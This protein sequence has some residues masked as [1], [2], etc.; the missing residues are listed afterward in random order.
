VASGTISRSRA[1]KLAGA[2]LL[3]AVLVPFSAA[4]VEAAT[5]RVCR[6]KAA[7]DNDKCP[8]VD[9]S[10]TNPRCECT[11]TVN[12]DKRCVDF[13][14]TQCPTRDECDRNRDCRRGE[15]CTK[16]GGCCGGSR[17]N[18]CVPLCRD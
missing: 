1:L 6:G 12:G 15:V 13:T 4:P 16:V 7:I 8:A 17:R 2:A 11:R 5:D 3:G 10:P 18:L 14:D 9:C